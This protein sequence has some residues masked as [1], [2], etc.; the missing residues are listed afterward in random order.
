[1][2]KQWKHIAL[3]AAIVL[4]L[5]IPGQ[6]VKYRYF[7]PVGEPSSLQPYFVGGEKCVECHKIEYDQWL[8]SHHDLAMDTAT[9]KS[10]LGNFDD[11]VFVS[12]GGDTSRFY[13]KEGKFYVHTKGPGGIP[14]DFQIAYTFGWWPLQQ[15]LIPFDKGRLQ[16]LN[17]TWDS[18]KNRWYDMAEA[19]YADQNITPDDWLYWTNQAQ[20]WNGMCA[21]CHSTHLQKNF[22]PSTHA[23]HTTWSDI[24]VNC[25][26]CHGPGSAHLDWAALPE[27]ARPA[28]NNAGL[29]TVT[30]DL[31]A[32]QYVDQ[33][34]RCHARRSA[35]GDF[36]HFDH[37]FLDNYVPELPH[38]PF[39]YSDGQILEEDYVYGSFTQ[40]KMFTNDVKCNDCHDPHSLDLV[41]TGNA[42]CLQCHRA[43][44]YDTPAHHFHKIADNPELQHGNHRKMVYKEGEGAL[45][46]N[47]H[48]NGQYYMGVDY[49]RDHSF[50]IPRPDLTIS[51]GVPN[52]CNSCHTD[53]TPQ[54]AEKYITLWYGKSRNAHYGSTIA[55][56]E[57]ADTSAIPRLI[58]IAT[59]SDDQYPAMVRATAMSLL[60]G[61][62]DQRCYQTI[63]TG[64][65]NPDPLVRTYA[66]QAYQPFDYDNLKNDLEPLLN[67]PVNAVR[68]EAADKLTLLPPEQ[69]DSMFIRPYH[70]ALKAFEDAMNY[71]ADFAAGRHSLGNLYANLGEKDSAIA[72]YLEALKI[73]K[74]FYPAKVNLAMIYNKNGENEKAEKLFRELIA[75]HPDL[76]DIY[77]SLGLLLAEMKKYDEAASVLQK[78]SELM[79]DRSR[80]YYNLGLLYQYLGRTDSAEKALLN[81]LTLENGNP[82]YIYALAEF[83]AKQGN[84]QKAEYYYKMLK[85]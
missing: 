28:N 58:G 12:N 30:H 5:T 42:L 20:N 59:A 75:E 71:T 82:E 49:R 66:V 76:Y 35:L 2:N 8:N 64:L 72:Q 4:A 77:Y 84:R 10:V 48:M 81:A 74:A 32:P 45:C 17:L 73:D 46:I 56:G 7:S 18:D 23:Y 51:L 21:E 50:R 53:K 34:A 40:S 16:T 54:W 14:G 38:E 37:A 47:C 44:I 31:S 68:I 57:N 41:K 25:E 15:Y 6:W 24:N 36:S 55:G 83:Y 70:E 78:A 43:E 85:R 65:N 61:Y 19:V 22:N 13:R 63:V 69:M 3:F 33:C 52:A 9:E 1:M 79:P 39:Y 11:K 60:A 80:I 67:D 26:S 29:V 62:Q 27:T